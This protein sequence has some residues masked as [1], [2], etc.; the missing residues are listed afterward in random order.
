MAGGWYGD[1]Y[2]DRGGRLEGNGLVFEP[3]KRKGRLNTLA[4]LIPVG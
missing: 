3:V 4:T 1:I 2:P